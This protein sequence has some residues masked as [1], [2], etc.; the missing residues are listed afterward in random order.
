MGEPSSRRMRAAKKL[1]MAAGV[2]TDARTPREEARENLNI[3][4]K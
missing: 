3:L 2:K 1:D 4:L